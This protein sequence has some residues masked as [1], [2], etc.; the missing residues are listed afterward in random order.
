VA[1]AGDVNGDGYADAVVGAPVYGNGQNMEGIALVWLGSAAGLNGGSSGT[2]ANPAWL[3]EVNQVGAGFGTC[4]AAIGD[5]SG[6]GYADLLVGS[7][8]FNGFTTDDGTVFAYYGNG[9]LGKSL[10]PRESRNDETAAIQRLA[11]SYDATQASFRLRSTLRTPFGRGKAKLQW[12]AKPLGNLFDGTGLGTAAAWKDTETTGWGA[13]E[14][15][16]VPSW[17]PQVHWRV[18]HLYNPVTTP[19]MPKSRW[20][21]RPWNGW[22]EADLRVAHDSGDLDNDGWANASDCA[23]ADGTVWALP[24]EATAFKFTGTSK[25]NFSWTAPANA[26]GTQTVL[27]DVLRS[28]SRQDFSS[29]TC[30]ASDITATSGSDATSPTSGQ[31]F[32]YLVGA[33]NSCG[34]N[35]GTN[36]AGTPRTGRNCP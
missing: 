30:V 28:L 21:T 10:R 23:P 26:G 2:P 33:Q 18:R 17:G 6:D 27:Y 22:Q 13:S 11:C 1:C 32:Y 35:F 7:P 8:F 9:Q 36:S 16:V 31:V 4:V 19:F 14:L 25:S 29:A 15:V 20:I 34:L 12:E 24:T 5:T 3:G